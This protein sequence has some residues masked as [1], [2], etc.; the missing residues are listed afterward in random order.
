MGWR[1][2]KLVDMRY[3][4][5]AARSGLVEPSPGALRPPRSSACAMLPVRQGRSTSQRKKHPEPSAAAQWS[6]LRVISTETASPSISLER[7]C[8]P[9]SR[10]T[11]HASPAPL[12]PQEAAPGY[13]LG[14]Q[15]V[16][17]SL[18]APRFYGPLC[19]CKNLAYALL[20]P[21]VG[22]QCDQCTSVQR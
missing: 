1:T 13:C 22:D 11:P 6:S 15:R 10:L 18:L 2:Q 8:C 17:I 21:L 12:G 5:R 19:D 14:L 4:R 7:S 16:P 9:A 20:A 3:R